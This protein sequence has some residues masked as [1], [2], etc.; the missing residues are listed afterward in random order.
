MV[1]KLELRIVAS[2]SRQSNTDY[3]HEA[4]MTVLLVADIAAMSISGLVGCGESVVME[5][6]ME[7]RFAVS[8]QVG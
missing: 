5:I 6:V 8:S 4:M 2:E 1:E 7:I 3:V